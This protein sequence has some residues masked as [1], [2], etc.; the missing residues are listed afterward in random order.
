MKTTYI[1]IVFLIAFTLHSCGV[2]Y[3]P[4]GGY[5]QRQSYATVHY[6]P[7]YYGVH[8]YG[9]NNHYRG[10]YYGG[11]HGGMHFGGGRR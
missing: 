11:E 4:R 6:A 7:R 5:Y 2:Y 3:E 10:G 1:I 9:G 8:H